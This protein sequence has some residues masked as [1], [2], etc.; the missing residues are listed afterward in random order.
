MELKIRYD[1]HT[2]QFTDFAT[3]FAIGLHNGV[4]HRICNRSD[5]LVEIR[6]EESAL[7]EKRLKSKTA[8]PE[9]RVAGEWFNHSRTNGENDKQQKALILRVVDLRTGRVS[10]VCGGFDG[11]GTAAAGIF[12]GRHW[13]VIAKMLRDKQCQNHCAAVVIVFDRSDP[14][15]GPAVLFKLVCRLDSQNTELTLTA[16]RESDTEAKY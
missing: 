12:L 3:N 5:G 13:Q 10:F 16:N 15:D 14:F 4:A 6:L 7:I 2:Y 1:T 11:Q 9:F 8:F